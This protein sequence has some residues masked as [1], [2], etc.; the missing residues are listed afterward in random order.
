MKRVITAQDVPGQRRAA[1]PG[2]HASLPPRRTKWPRARG[3]R[4]LEVPDDQ[5]STARAAGADHRDRRR[6]RRLSP[7]GGAQAVLESL[8]LAV[9]DVGVLRREA[10]RLP[11]YRA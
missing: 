4:I 8:G 2:G 5:F 6:S 1:R 11:R 10:R 7:E 9:R 3:V